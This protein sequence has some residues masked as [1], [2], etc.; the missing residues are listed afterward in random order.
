MVRRRLP[1]LAACLL[2]L[3]VA[4]GCGNKDEHPGVDEPAREG[5]AVPLDGVEYNVF[6]SREL[7]RRLPEDS[8]Y[9]K[10]PEAPPGEILFGVFLQACNRS[11]ETK[12]TAEEFAIKD[13]QGEIFHPVELEQD[14][15]FGYHSRSLAPKE[16][17]PK[18][19]SLAQLGPTGGSMLLFRLPI[20]KTENRPLELEVE[21]SFDPVEAKREKLT[22]ELDI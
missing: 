19:G 1:P 21:G 15:E 8:A 17:I 18:D 7:N 2:A 11:G 14:N 13:N 9:Y 6:L 12:R 22:F 5:L 10:G 4:A 16:C 3:A 20:E